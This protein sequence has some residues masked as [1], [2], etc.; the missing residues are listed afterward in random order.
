MAPAHKFYVSMTEIE[1]E[2]EEK[3]M[4]ITSRFFV[5]DLERALNAKGN[6]KIHEKNSP[7]VSLQIKAYYMDHFDLWD[8]Q[9]NIV[10]EFIGYELEDDLIW[11]YA[12]CNRRPNAKSLSAKADWLCERFD[13][14]SN[15]LHL[16]NPEG[17]KT[18]ILNAGNSSSSFDQ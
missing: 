5:D 3:V 12:Q 1:W 17:M 8:N 15:I 7:E 13:E 10:I 9:G 14:Q 6:L 16:K 2:A 4:G 11:C 18:M